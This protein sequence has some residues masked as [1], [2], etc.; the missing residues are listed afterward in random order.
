M[1]LWGC[2]EKPLK[3]VAKNASVMYWES[4]RDGTALAFRRPPIDKI[5]D[6]PIDNTPQP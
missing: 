1:T 6:T 2:K 3:L 4:V 5:Y